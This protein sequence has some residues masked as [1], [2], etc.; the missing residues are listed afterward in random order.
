[1][2]S[3]TVQPIRRKEQGKTRVRHSFGSRQ[4]KR[5]ED[6]T[7]TTTSYFDYNLML[8]DVLWAHYAL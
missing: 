3:K 7:S 8:F 6:K 5:K 2:S 4:K 1:M